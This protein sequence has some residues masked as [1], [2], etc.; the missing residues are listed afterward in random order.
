MSLERF[1]D[2]QD[3]PH[4]LYATHSY[5]ERAFMEIRSGKKNTHWMWFI[6]PQM[7]GL[8]KSQQSDYYGLKDFTEAEAYLQ[9][10]TLGPRLID[11]SAL[12]LTL[13]EKHPE[14]IFGRDS[15]KLHSCMTL[16]SRVKHAHPVFNEVIQN[17]F[18][19]NLDI[20]TLKIVG[21]TS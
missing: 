9:H 3:N 10:P 17:F 11:I 16:F 5:Y 6:Y 7:K 19:Q 18:K 21:L 1:V 15:Q 4:Y 14:K 12:L 8:G 13:N 20:E 2:A